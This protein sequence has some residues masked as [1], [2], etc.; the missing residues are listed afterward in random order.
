M[1]TNWTNHYYLQCDIKQT[2]HI[3]NSNF[4]DNYFHEE[5]CSTTF[6]QA[7]GARPPVQCNL[8][9]NIFMCIKRIDFLDIV[10]TLY[11]NYRFQLPFQRAYFRHY[12][13]SMAEVLHHKSIKPNADPVDFDICL[14]QVICCFYDKDMNKTKNTY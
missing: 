8:G 4:E 14:S 7:L 12:R 10:F 9:I 3:C 2:I 11:F 6:S 5:T 1:K 13:F